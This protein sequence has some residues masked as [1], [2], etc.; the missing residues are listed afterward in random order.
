LRYSSEKVTVYIK[1]PYLAN[2]T[3]YARDFFGVGVGIDSLAEIPSYISKTMYRIDAYLRNKR[4]TPSSKEDDEVFSFYLALTLTALA[5]PWALSKFVDYEA[6]RSRKFLL[7]EQDKLLEILARKLSLRLE[8][9]GSDVNKCG[10]AVLI[11]EDIKTGKTIVECYQFR[12]PITQYLI[13]AEKLLTEPK[14]KLVNR[15][16]K[17][18]YVYLNKRDA[19]R[20]LEEAIKKYI[21]D[22]VVKSI[23]IS[24][25][26]RSK[27]QPLVSKVL[28]IVRDVR[29]YIQ[30]EEKK[31]ELPSGIIDSSLFPPCIKLIYDAILRG[32]HLSHHQRFALA[33]FL[34]NLGA[35]VDR[36]LEIFK[37]SPDFNERVAR[38]QVEHLAGIRGSRKKYYVYSCEKMRT[39][40]LC[41][42]DCGTKSPLQ[43]YRKMLRESL[44]KKRS[45]RNQESR[46]PQEH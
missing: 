11:G 8:Y 5:D 4:Y 31:E 19:T 39:L 35:D 34:L 42:S 36:V 7:S 29:G 17:Q 3:D 20:L 32:E 24:A 41:I 22:D 1:Y 45:F 26:V 40:G 46:N 30:R 37:H 18:G 43:Y 15:L 12:V 21:L 2:L 28:E 25:E 44:S 16:V 14:W 38:Y 13:V 10:Y 6:K 9:L 33:T 27:L 23:T